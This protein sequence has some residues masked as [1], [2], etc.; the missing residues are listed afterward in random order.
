MS[1]SSEELREEVRAEA[2]RE[3]VLR[4]G[5]QRF[6]KVAGRK[7]KTLLNAVTDVARLE[8]ILDRILAATSWEDLLATP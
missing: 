3:A 4:L 7:Q 5:R 8:R 1:Q 2:L 6:G